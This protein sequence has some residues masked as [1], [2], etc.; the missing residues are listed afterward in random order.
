MRLETAVLAEHEA[1]RKVLDL[2]SFRR[3]RIDRKYQLLPKVKSEA[4]ARFAAVADANCV[5][6]GECLEH[7]LEV[8]EASPKGASD[9]RPGT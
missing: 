3:R 6:F 2:K 9:D 5:C 4:A 8:Y 1:P 7:N